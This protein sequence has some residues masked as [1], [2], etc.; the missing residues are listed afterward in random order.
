MQSSRLRLYAPFLALVLAQAAFVVITPSSGE[1]R[2]PLAGVQTNAGDLSAGKLDASGTAPGTYVDPATGEVVT[3]AA[4]GSVT[5]AA[6]PP[7]GAPAG[8]RQTA[9]VGDTSH[10]T[11]SGKQSDVIVTAPDCKPKFVGN[12]GGPTYPG[13]TAKEI[14]FIRFSCQANEQVNAILATQGLAASEEETDAMIQATMD[15][16]HKTYEFYGRKLVYQRVIGDCP[17]APDDPAKSRQAAAEVVKMQPF[18]VIGGSPSAL[19][20]FA[21][22]GIISLGGVG[23]ADAFFSGRRPFRWDIFPDG[24]ESAEWLAEYYCKKLTGK[25]ADHAGVVIHTSIGGRNTPRRAAILSFDNGDGTTTPNV[26]RAAELINKCSKG[27][28]PVLYYQSD[29]NRATEQTRA[30]VA[31]LIDEKVTTLIC[32]CDPIAPVF[33]T[34]GL[35]QNNYYPEHMLSGMYLID[36]DVLGR[37]YDQA[38]WAHAFGPSHLTDQTD[39]SQSNAARIW[40]ASGREGEPCAACNLVTGYMTDLGSKIHYAGPNLNPLTVEKGLVGDRVHQGGW[41]ETKGNP[42]DYFISYGPG[43][44]NAISD[45]REVYWDATAASEIDGK[46]GR[47]ISMNKGRRYIGGE[48]DG[49]LDIPVRPQ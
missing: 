31:K 30:I 49:R 33:L 44:Y 24:T 28:I 25:P 7:G 41:A 1:T 19:D 22:N 47:Y 13:A 20:V 40:R 2:D 43:D 26:D 45:F 16:M 29:I 17:S 9:V 23:H 5:R 14:K 18:A 38:Q 21:Q 8:S 4:D 46:P 11:E 36:Y 48:L 15:W 35:T 32:M 27:N 10:C 37:L 34:N 3:V 6:A 12:N 42:Y 39:F